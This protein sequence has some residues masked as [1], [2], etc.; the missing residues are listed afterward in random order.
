MSSIMNELKQIKARDKVQPTVVIEKAKQSNKVKES[1]VDKQKTDKRKEVTRRAEAVRSKK[2]DTTTE[3]T[4]R[5][6]NDE[7]KRART[8][9][10][11]ASGEESEAFIEVRRKK[12]TYAK[13]AGSKRPVDKNTGWRTPENEERFEAI[14]NVQGSEKASTTVQTIRKVLSDDLGDL[15]HLRGVHHIKDGS[16]LMRFENERQRAAATAKLGAKVGEI[17]VRE[18]GMSKPRFAIL[19]MYKGYS[20][21]TI[22]AMLLQE[23]EDIYQN[24]GERFITGTK[25]ITR[26]PCR[27]EEKESVVFEADIDIFKHIVKAKRLWFD[28][29]KLLVQE[30]ILVPICYK[31]NK[32]GHSQRFCTEQQFCGGPHLGADC[33][34]ETLD[35]PNCKQLGIEK[36]QRMHSARDRD[37][38]IF[39]RYENRAR[40]GI[41]YK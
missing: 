19:G 20:E 6:E 27:N 2:Y 9:N 28:L 7:A 5:N 17:T 16:V 32:Y 30:D 4:G 11:E 25:E 21:N 13:I 10:G 40:K 41:N 35:C 29:S 12:K 8:T 33:R 18:R 3:D 24:F 36:R 38:P 31:C 22:K 1:M 23:N 39:V 26:R 14:V 34:A 37:C 15:G